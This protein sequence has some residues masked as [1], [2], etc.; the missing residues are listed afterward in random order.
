MHKKMKT[1]IMLTAITFTMYGCGEQHKAESVVEDFLAENI[2]A[3]DYKV[4]FSDIDSTRHVT[5]SAVN[6]MRAEAA[7]NKM[8]KKG[9]KYAETD[10]KYIYT[11]VDIYV[12]R[13]T[14]SH[15]FYITPD[16]GRVVSFKEN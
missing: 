12:G 2:Q 11:K 7:R 14:V 3:S 16:L 4:V 15:T 5:D 1:A 10:K 9:I 6:A 8:F 13:D